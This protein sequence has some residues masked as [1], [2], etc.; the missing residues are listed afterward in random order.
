MRERQRREQKESEKEHK[1]EKQRE[2]MKCPEEEQEALAAAET[3]HAEEG[4]ELVWYLSFGSN[5]NAMVLTERRQVKPLR[6]HACSLPDYFLNMDYMGLAY[7]EP[8]FGSISKEPWNGCP[9]RLRDVEVQGVVHHITRKEFSQIQLTEGGGGHTGV[10]YYPEEVE[11]LTYEGERIRALTLIYK[12]T[13]AD[14]L[15]YPSKRYLSLLIHGAEQSGLKEEY[16]GYLKALP[17]YEAPNTIRCFID[18]YLLAL[19]FLTVM[20]PCFFMLGLSRR[21]FKC[22]GPVVV[23]HLLD[24]ATRFVYGLN[25][26]VWKYLFHVKCV[27]VRIPKVREK[28][29]QN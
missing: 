1:E 19:I 27:E 5:M 6:S 24:Y 20:A 29:N 25:N 2:K 26:Y 17:Y 12:V 22:S 11:V 7:F 10:G 18:K 15:G 3:E 21:L 28:D 8:S 23:F 14:F 13:N 4:E 16:V 9:E